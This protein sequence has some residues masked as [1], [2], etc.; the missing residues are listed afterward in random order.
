ME[1]SIRPISCSYPYNDVIKGAFEN[2]RPEANT[3][4]SIE[5]MSLTDK[6]KDPTDVGNM[7]CPRI[8][9]QQ[10]GVPNMGRPMSLWAT[11]TY[12]Y[13]LT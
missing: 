11:L 4:K 7:W 10:S 9:H 12:P 5:Y 1:E 8:E 13:A 6:V 3:A 2:L